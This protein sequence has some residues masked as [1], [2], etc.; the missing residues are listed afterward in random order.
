MLGNVEG[1][2]MCLGCRQ[3]VPKASLYYNKAM[4]VYY[5][6]QCLARDRRR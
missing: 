1:E 2:A 5:H 3:T 6:A 4:D